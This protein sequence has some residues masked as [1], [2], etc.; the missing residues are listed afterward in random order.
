MDV[1]RLGSQRLQNQY[2][3]NADMRLPDHLAIVQQKGT[4]GMQGVGGS[5]STNN[6]NRS[7]NAPFG[8]GK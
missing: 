3:Q 1:V 4:A 7:R 5:R 2:I 6:K 8:Q